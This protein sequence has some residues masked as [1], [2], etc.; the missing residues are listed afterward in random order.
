LYRCTREPSANPAI[1]KRQAIK[2]NESAIR[3]IHS[4]RSLKNIERVV[5]VPKKIKIISTIEKSAVKASIS[6]SIFF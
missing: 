4:A 1:I 6:K 2:R 3:K 5:I